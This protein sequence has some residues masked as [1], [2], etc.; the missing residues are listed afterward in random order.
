LRLAFVGAGRLG[1]SI[2]QAAARAGYLVAAVSSR[3]PLQRALLSGR[4][5]EA[6]IFDSAAAAADRADIVFITASDAAVS[7]V[8]E[9]IE[10]RSG[11]SAIHCAGAL[12]LDALSAAERADADTGALHPLQTFPDGNSQ[13]RLGGVTFA[14]ESKNAVLREWLHNFARNLGGRP[15]DINPEHRAAYHASA[16]LASGLLAGLT[17]LAADMWQQMGVSRADALAALSPLIK[18]TADAVSEKGVPSALTGPYV[19]GDV[20]TIT[21][22]LSATA[23]CSPDVARAYAA[24]ALAHLPIAAERGNLTPAARQEIETMLRKSLEGTA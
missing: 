1:S 16:V 13:S 2:A 12:G 19:R 9:S 8:C 10:W 22:H 20:D 21:R 4:L 5:P 11:K 15:F 17:G 6:E 23:V 3:R 7:Q 14:I 18:A 24:L